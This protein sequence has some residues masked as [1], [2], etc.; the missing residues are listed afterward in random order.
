M[1]ILGV[2]VEKK[3]GIIM[4]KWDLGHQILGLGNR[5]TEVKHSLWFESET[6]G[7]EVCVSASGRCLLVRRV[8]PGAVGCL[9]PGPGSVL[10]SC[11][12][13]WAPCQP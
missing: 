5:F 8:S 3:W 12:W 2:M 1:S 10:G 13:F 6:L 4:R 9:A 7:S 11:Q